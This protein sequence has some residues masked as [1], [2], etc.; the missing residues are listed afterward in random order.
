MSRP[1]G[2]DS[3]DALARELVEL[4]EQLLARDTAFRAWDERVA[5]LEREKEDLAREMTQ[6]LDQAAAEIRELSGTIAEMQATRI[7]RIGE[8]YWRTRGRLK[9]LLQRRS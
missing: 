1:D 7:W 5:A 2:V 9:K 8:R 4:H 3:Q 6:R